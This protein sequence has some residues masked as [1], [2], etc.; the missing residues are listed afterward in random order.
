MTKFGKKRRKPVK[1]TAEDFETVMQLGLTQKEGAQHLDICLSSFKRQ[2]SKTSLKWPSLNELRFHK[3]HR[4]MRIKLGRMIDMLEVELSRDIDEISPSTSSDDSN[5]T[6]SSTTFD[7]TNNL[8]S[9]TQ[10]VGITG[11]PNFIKICSPFIGDYTMING[12]WM[13]NLNHYIEN[14]IGIVVLDPCLNVIACNQLYHN[15]LG[16]SAKEMFPSFSHLDKVLM[17]VFNPE[18]YCSIFKRMLATMNYMC[19]QNTWLTKN[20]TQIFLKITFKK[21]KTHPSSPY[22]GYFEIEPS[23]S[24]L[25][26]YTIGEI[27]I[28]KDPSKNLVEDHILT[29]SILDSNIPD[30]SIISSN[31]EGEEDSVSNSL[32]LFQ[33][34]SIDGEIE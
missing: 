24:S 20:G 27:I 18:F 13:L 8:I 3:H 6:L 25:P 9:G 33:D 30:E 16:Y 14:N 19:F 22:F 32:S 21:F 15:I 4:E 1:L 5:Q 28:R 17:K 11:I 26:T 10:I 2:F 7:K 23:F 29:F 34:E 12:P 31:D